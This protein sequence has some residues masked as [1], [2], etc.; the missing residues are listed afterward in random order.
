MENLPVRLVILNLNTEKG[1]VIS[2]SP[3]WS[4]LPEPQSG[5]IHAFRV[6]N[7]RPNVNSSHSRSISVE[8]NKAYLR[9][10]RRGER[11]LSGPALPLIIAHHCIDRTYLLNRTYLNV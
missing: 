4:S 11:E 9:L 7:I 8:A 5:L 2:R 6:I 1:A 3:A 10:Y